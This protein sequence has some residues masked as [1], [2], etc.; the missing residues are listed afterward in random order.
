MCCGSVA[1]IALV[2]Y[3]GSRFLAVFLRR[4]MRFSC[5]V[6]DFVM[7]GCN[8]VLSLVVGGWVIGHIVWASLWYPSMVSTT[9]FAAKS[10]CSV[11]TWLD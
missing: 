3:L 8:L 11:M 9:I 2:F 10:I 7:G 5:I 4:V 1:V 6:S